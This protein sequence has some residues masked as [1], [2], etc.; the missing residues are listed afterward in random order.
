MTK[1]MEALCQG[2]RSSEMFGSDQP[3]DA[4]DECV[5]VLLARGADIFQVPPA[6]RPVMRR[7][8]HD[9][10]QLALVPQ[11]LN[12]AVVGVATARR[13]TLAQDNI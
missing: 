9:L 8:L 10:A 5:S 11:L 6:C 7:V 2:P 12:E 1:V 4:R 3:D 13:Q